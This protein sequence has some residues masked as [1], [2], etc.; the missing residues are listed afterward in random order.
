MAD[1]VEKPDAES[2]AEPLADAKPDRT[3]DNSAVPVVGLGA[4][5]GGIEAL[6]Q[7][8]DTMPADSNLVFVVVL[9]LDP[10]RQSLLSSILSHHTAMPVIEIEDGIEIAPNKVYVI[11][12]NY[13]LTLD[14]NALRL[15]DPAQPRGHRHP[16]DVLFQSLAEQRA[17]RS[18]A[19]ILSGTGTNG[20]QGLREV[21]ANGGLILVQ[22]P[23]TASFDGMPR[24]AIGAGLADHVLA[25]ADMPAALL[26]YFQHGYVAAPD[27]LGTLPGSKQPGLE[28][29]FGLLRAHSGHDFHVY[30]PATLRRRINR[31][32]SL[33]SLSSLDEYIARLRSDPVEVKALVRDLLISVTSFFRDEDAWTALDDIVISQLVADRAAGASIRVWVPA[34]AT[35]EEAYSVAMLLQERAEAAHKQFDLKIFASDIQDDNLNVA[36]AGVYPSASVE[37][38]A[39]ERYLRFFDRLDGSYQVRKS[40]RDLVVFARQNLLHDPPFSRMDLITCR[41]MLIYVDPDAQKRALALFHFALREGGRLFLGSAETVG[42]SDDLF[43]T[44]S[45]KWRIYRR[46]GPTRHDIVDFPRL[47]GQASGSRQ[48]E[49]L[50]AAEPLVRVS[51]AARR[52][53]LDRYA[54]ASVLIDQRGRVLYFHGDTGD[55]LKQ[56]NG[57]PTRDLLAM[58]REGL[59][60][61]LRGAIQTAIADKQEIRFDTQI[62][63]GDVVRTVVVTLF[64]LAA[65]PPTSAMTL[66]TFE[67]AAS[68]LPAAPSMKGIREEHEAASVLESELRSTRAELQ[69]TIE[70]LESVNEELKASNEEATSMNE[71]L[72]STNEELETSR[73]ELQSFNEELHSVNSQ[74]QHKINELDQTSN[75]LANLL[76]GT[77]IATVFLDTEFR[78]QWFS[79]A[80]KPLLELVLSDVGRPISHFAR[81]FDDER[82][83]DDADTVLAKLTP[84]EVEI[85]GDDG[86]WFLRR[87]LPYRTRDNRIASLVVTFIDITERRQATD[88]IDEARIYAEAIVA[89]ARQPLVVLDAGLHVRSA[90]RA[91][92]TLLDTTPDAAQHLRLYELGNG[93][94]DIPELRRLLDEVLPRDERFDGVEVGLGPVGPDQRTMLL[95]ARKLARNGGREELILL[96]IEEI[97]QRKR[98]AARQDMLIGEL[99][100]RVKNV[101][102]TVLAIMAQTFRQ[103]ASPGDFQT[104][105]EGRLH[106]LAQAHDLLAEKEWLGTRLDQ[107]VRQTLA[108]YSLLD[109]SRIVM[110]GPSLTV[111]S[112]RGVALVMILHELTTNAAK[113]GALSVPNGKLAVTWRL[114]DDGASER[115][116]LLWTETGGPNV[117]Q[118]TR[119]GFGTKLIRRSTVHELGGEAHIEYLAEGLRCALI[120]PW[121]GIPAQGG[122]VG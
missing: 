72:Q 26:R 83:L 35:G 80:T 70:Q 24:S 51:E 14:G 75:D 43:E 13:D 95:N 92:Y 8:F 69:G 67:P 122:T 71:E 5:A 37:T 34:C 96:A 41:N 66:V 114:I 17:E 50:P 112:Q 29:L 68:E 28:S 79:P 105:F 107:I 117:T 81:K 6:G 94:W 21:K 97:T 44:V 100:H 4:S 27:G 36:R 108:P 39:P 113:H 59:L 52:A 110:D 109:S 47:G 31:R 119:Q 85:R 18:A 40:L 77:E 60:A 90:N 42:R 46:S 22:D 78:I 7:F 63:Q 48:Q 61:K 10:T 32:M 38:M 88:A 49:V 99:N 74:L 56:P 116:H 121:A 98:D 106:A 76:S 104:A 93:E 30:K 62:R 1:E 111:R 54:P 3:S 115:I 33:A 53:L 9:H 19:I 82:L 86:K 16:V 20:T 102:A 91:F 65:L 23:A 103:S 58:A 15:T 2:A 118:P 101:L 87:I 64:P 84:I 11:A 57:E 89:T 25:P 12:P 55:Y 45:K 73:E 120:F